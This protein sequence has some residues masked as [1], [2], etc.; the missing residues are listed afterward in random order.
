MEENNFEKRVQQE[1]SDLRIHPSDAVWEN[2]KLRIEK[3]K[4]RRR[5]FLIFFLGVLL[6]SGGYFIF[7]SPRP[8]KTSETTFNND[9]KEKA[10]NESKD[11][12]DTIKQSSKDDGMPTADIPILGNDKITSAKSITS[13]QN[14]TSNYIIKKTETDRSITNKVSDNSNNAGDEGVVAFDISKPQIIL[15]DLVVN[16]KVGEP[17]ISK[18]ITGTNV[19]N[20]TN[21][22]TV[23]GSRDT[24][25]I[26]GI[27]YTSANAKSQ[28]EDN[29]D[30]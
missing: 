12:D 11:K 25:I 9:S 5:V 28:Q 15:Q 17:E 19:L 27:L 22:I 24:L 30:V 10:I 26:T 29:Y 2:V 23:A 7:N 18:S 16:N 4:S 21:K 14:K 1:M 20:D 8:L 13:A 3:K 6:L